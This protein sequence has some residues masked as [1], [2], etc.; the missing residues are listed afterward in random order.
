MRTKDSTANRQG[1]TTGW[2]SRSPTGGKSR[3]PS[4]TA[5]PGVSAYLKAQDIS[6]GIVT[7]QLPQSSSN[8]VGNAG[9]LLKE[10]SDYLSPGHSL[11]ISGG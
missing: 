11:E 5:T 6:V 8:S 4:S 3:L 1:A 2:G 10:L 9:I 7:T